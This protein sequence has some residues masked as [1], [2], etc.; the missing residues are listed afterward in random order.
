MHL[1]FFRYF[2]GNVQLMDLGQLTA[3]LTSPFVEEAKALHAFLFL[4]KPLNRMYGIDIIW[5]SLLNFQ[6]L[7]GCDRIYS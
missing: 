1:M 6:K 7:C 5:M 3:Q 2:S 4:P